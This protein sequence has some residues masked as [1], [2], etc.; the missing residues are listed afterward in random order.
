MAL[1]ASPKLSVLVHVEHELYRESTVDVGHKPSIGELDLHNFR[2]I[3]SPACS[4]LT[5]R[6]SRFAL[7]LTSEPRV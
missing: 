1:L 6:C 2:S 3:P 5:P 4:S 7:C